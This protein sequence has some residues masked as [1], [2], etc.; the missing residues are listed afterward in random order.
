MS[1]ARP[2]PALRRPPRPCVLSLLLL[3]VLRWRRDDFDHAKRIEAGTLCD[4][5]RVAGGRRLEDEEAEFVL[6][7]VD[8]AF[9][10]DARP[11]PRQVVRGRTCTA[12]ARDPL[13]R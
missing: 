2:A 11:F 7:Q 8:R 6:R 5:D 1:P 3:F 13:S 12:L 4:E 9:E 10:P